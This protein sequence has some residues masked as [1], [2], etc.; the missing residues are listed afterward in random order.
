MSALTMIMICERLR[1]GLSVRLPAMRAN[2]FSEL[3]NILA[4][5]KESVE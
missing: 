5:L 2:E 3:L 1:K 4:F